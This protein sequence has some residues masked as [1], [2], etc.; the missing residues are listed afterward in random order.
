MSKEYRY[1]R[2]ENI[3]KWSGWDIV[4]ILPARTSDKVNMAVICKEGT[5][6]NDDVISELVERLEVFKTKIYIDGVELMIIPVPDY[7][8]I[9]EETREKFNDR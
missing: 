1:V 6:K 5:P 7:N 9:I 2:L 3:D 8:Q 4:E